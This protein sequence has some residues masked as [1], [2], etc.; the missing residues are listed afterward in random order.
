MR[1]ALVGVGRWG[2]NHARVLG[3]LKRR[4]VCEEVIVCDMNE[5]AAKEAV[6]D[7]GLDRYYSDLSEL[8]A[9]EHPDAAIIAVPTLHHYEVASKLLPHADV[10]IEKPIAADLEQ[11]RRLIEKALR[12]GRVIAVGHIE[13]FNRGVI[14]VKDE[15]SK[16]LKRGDRI[17]YLSAQRL[18]PGPPAGSKQNLGVAH[19]LLVH[20]IDIASYIIGNLPTSVSAISL[21]E[22]GLEVEVI[23]N[24]L[25]KGGIISTLRASWR[26]YPKLKKRTLTVQTMEEIITL[27]YILQTYHIERG[28][29]DNVSNGGYIGIIFSYQAR[30]VVEKRIMPYDLKEPLMDEDENFLISVRKG[31]RPLVSGVEGYVA[32]KCAIYALKS[33]KEGKSV[34]LEWKES[35][36][37]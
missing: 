8:I 16:A 2:R 25:Y 24:F 33:A 20:D 6:R 3:E 35:F 7:Y 14:A 31:K 29:M 18:G 26:T 30:E 37:P 5:E 1:V 21:E 17:V 23:A 4:G 15:V 9:K 34:K 13:R 22:G 12:Y 27:D 10:L 19:D 11:A 36:L 28:L 32:L